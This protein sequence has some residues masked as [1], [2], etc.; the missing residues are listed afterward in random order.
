MIAIIGF[1]LSYSLASFYA[2]KDGE[3]IDPNQ[4]RKLEKDSL[5]LW[6]NEHACGTTLSATFSF[7]QCVYMKA[8]TEEM[9]QS[10]L[11]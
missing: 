4:V 6:Q 7:N 10:L 3:K 5:N 8:R 2:H 1:S 11:V 9:A